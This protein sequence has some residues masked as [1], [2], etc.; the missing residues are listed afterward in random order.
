MI[1]TL[2]EN[3]FHFGVWEWPY[4][5]QSITNLFQQGENNHFFITDQRGGTGKVANGGGWHGSG[6]AFIPG[7]GHIGGSSG[8][9]SGDGGGTWTVVPICPA[10]PGPQSPC[11]MAPSQGCPNGSFRYA[12]FAGAAADQ[13][14]FNNACIGPG[15]RPIS[16]AEMSS[17]VRDRVQQVAPPL[18][19]GFQPANGALTQL[20][21][22][23]RS[24]QA[25]SL[26][27]TDSIAGFSVRLRATA[28]WRWVWGDRTSSTTT[29]PGG[30]YPDMSV[31]HTY[32]RAGMFR[33]Q[34][35]TS[36]TASYF[37]DGGGPYAVIGGPV[38]Q[39]GSLP[40]PVRQSRAV[41][42]E[43]S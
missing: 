35:I 36:W 34:V 24:G 5:D 6:S 43:D 41:L 8:S 21:T 17:M 18:R 30:K 29:R 23:F 12:V 42:V 37:V 26:S 28:S 11:G 10:N 33:A 9:S 4:I 14:F 27:R 16:E 39:L 32:R 2:H 19:P 7:G 1:S 15:E 31:S 22:V 20:P 25:K 3:H 13:K 40:V 38:T